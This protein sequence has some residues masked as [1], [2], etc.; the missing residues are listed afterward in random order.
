MPA[1]IP[2]AASFDEAFGDGQAETGPSGVTPAGAVAPV[3]DVEHAIEVLG[4]YATALVGDRHEQGPV[5]GL[6]VD[7]DRP[8][9]LGVP[10]GVVE[11]VAQDAP[12]VDGRD[13]RVAGIDEIDNVDGSS[14]R[15]G[16]EGVDRVGDDVGHGFHRAVDGRCS[17]LEPRQFEEVVD[18]RP[19]SDRLVPY[20][21][22]VAGSVGRSVD[23]VVFEQFR[24][25]AD[26]GD[27]AAEIVAGPRHE[28]VSRLL[29]CLLPAPRRLDGGRTVH[30]PLPE[31]GDLGDLGARD[32]R[33]VGGPVGQGRRA[34]D[35]TS[36]S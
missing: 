15:G 13:R 30:Q 31:T 17:A 24:H 10:Y 11:Q 8:A 33:G 4:R 25:G 20:R 3:A 22:V 1:A 9:R 29:E 16:S 36:A 34:T 12:E 5:D 21:P 35:S 18:E 27:G 28:L 23:E 26:G 2:P 6:A 32:G 7:D 19:E 14:G